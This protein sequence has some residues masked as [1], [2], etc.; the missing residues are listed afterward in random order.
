M[1]ASQ[2]LAAVLALVI[3]G[4]IFTTVLPVAAEAAT[5]GDVNSAGRVNS[6]DALFL[7]YF[8]A[9]FICQLPPPDETYCPQSDPKYMQ[10]ADVNED[11]IDNAIDAIF[12]LQYHAGLLDHLPV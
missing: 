7:L 10:S 12:I 6:I 11:G 2:L 5:P 9:G 3:I 1:S 4:T 8:R